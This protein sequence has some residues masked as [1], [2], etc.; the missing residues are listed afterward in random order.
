MHVKHDT[1]S[2]RFKISLRK[3][4]FR[5]IHNSCHFNIKSVLLKTMNA[6]RLYEEKAIMQYEDLR[7]TILVIEA[8]RA[9]RGKKGVDWAAFKTKLRT[10]KK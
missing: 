4:V 2:S 10:R 8:M 9:S 5:H 3:Y 6:L 7:D 1:S